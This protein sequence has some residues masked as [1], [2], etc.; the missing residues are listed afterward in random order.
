MSKI[1]V[2]FTGQGSQHVGMGKEFLATSEGAQVRAEQARVLLGVD[3]PAMCVD[4]PEEV[5]TRSDRA[6]PAIFL[7]SFLA[8]EAYLARGGKVDF[9]AGH[10][11]GEWTALAAAGVV[12]FEDTL[13]ILEARGRFMQ[14]A[15][16]H[17][18]GAMLAL[19]G[20]VDLQAAQT[21]ARD[22]G[23]QVANLNSPAQVI[24]S[25]TEE[26]IQQAETLSGERGLKGRRLPVA[27]AFHSRLMQGAADR[28][29]EFLR[30]IPMREPELPVCCNVT[31]SMHHDPESIRAAMVA[32]VT[33][34]VRWI[35]NIEGL[36]SLGVS[37]YVECGPKPVLTGLVKRIDNEGGLHN[38]HDP[39]SLEKTIEALCLNPGATEGSI[40][41]TE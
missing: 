21:L 16:E 7:V 40:K 4:G 8:W 22:A 30:E 14:E 25:G 10:S 17:S 28:F 36:K 6:Q 33:S 23:V 31:G 38:V 35:E 37:Q 18:P 3:L 13:R 34:P 26:G 24:L 39:A 27:G 2:M 15:C 29:A 32:Q 19:L 1:A 12:S 11:L 41:E 20:N 5:L 9:L